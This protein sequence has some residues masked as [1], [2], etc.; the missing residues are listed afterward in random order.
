MTKCR[1]CDED[2]TPKY[3][4]CE[5]CGGS[6]EAPVRPLRIQPVTALGESINR[7]ENSLSVL[8]RI[9]AAYGRHHYEDGET[10]EEALDCA[11]EII[12]TE[13][14]EVAVFPDGDTAR[15]RKK[16][17]RTLR[18]IAKILETWDPPEST[19]PDTPLMTYA[20]TSAMSAFAFVLGES[21][22]WVQLTATQATVLQQSLE[23]Y[24][25]FLVNV[26]SVANDDT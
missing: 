23:V 11:R 13:E 17:Q 1:T 25:S 8:K 7:Y 10:L 3:G 19:Q 26:E 16:S 6:G 15:L 4:E 9:V 20:Q 2:F 14:M 21:F 12:A 5:A 24:E 22:P 18:I